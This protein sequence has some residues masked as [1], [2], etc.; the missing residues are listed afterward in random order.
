VDDQRVGA[1][2]RAVRL[3]RRLRQVDVAT[4]AR[5][6]H[7]TVSRIERGFVASFKLETIRAVA[8]VLEVRIDLAPWSRGGDLYRMATEDHSALVESVVRELTRLGWETRAEVSF[9]EFGERGFIDILAWHPTSRTLLVIEIKTEIV[10]VGETVGV[11]H[12]KQRL[13][14]TIA[15]GLGWSPAI[16]SC[17]LIARDTRTNRRRVAAHAATFRS[18]LPT[19]GH[20]LRAHLRRPVG[21]VAAV[22]FWTDS[23]G[24]DGSQR[25]GGPRRVRRP[26]SKRA[27][28]RSNGDGGPRQAVGTPESAVSLT[29][30]PGA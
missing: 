3:R 26:A 27:Q 18:L 5:V 23:R 12:R 22:A 10:D 4:A 24:R 30:V 14:A 6:S 20:A 19:D 1:I 16:V 8:R 29:T 17:A 28:S 7:Q 2:L 13:A 11:L 9:S 25:S 15:R 21:S